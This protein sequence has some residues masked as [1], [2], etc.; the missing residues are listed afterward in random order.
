MLTALALCRQPHIH[1]WNT[2][3]A[4]DGAIF[5]HDANAR[6]ALLTLFKGYAG[7]ANLAPRLLALPTA[8][9]P[10]SQFDRALAVA[11]AAFDVLLALFVFG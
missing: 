7:Y 6:P 10:V 4:E 5:A 2:I 9:V 8:V 1:V 3:W 11:S